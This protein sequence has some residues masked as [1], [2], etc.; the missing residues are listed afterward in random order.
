MFSDLINYLTIILLISYLIYFNKLNVQIGFVLAGLSILPIFLI[1]TIIPINLVSDVIQYTLYT[2]H[3]RAE[4]GL[5]MPVS[6]E[7]LNTLS[8][9][10]GQ[11]VDRIGL[12]YALMPIPFIDNFK[13]IG[14]NNKFLFI[15]LIS[16]IY[17]QKD[18]R[19]YFIIFFLLLY[20]SIIFYSSTGL[21]DTLVLITMVPLA[22][23]IVEKKILGTILLL[24]ILY[25]FRSVNVYLLVPII[26]AY[27]IIFSKIEIPIKVVFFVLASII[28]LIFL[29]IKADSILDTLNSYRLVRAAE[30]ALAGNPIIA[31]EVTINLAE[32]IYQVI[33]SIIIDSIRFFTLPTIF[34]AN[35]NF[36]IIQSVENIFVMA[37]V[38]YLFYKLYLIDKMKCLFWILSLI[39]I[40]GVYGYVQT[41][42]GTLVRYKFVFIAMFTTLL[43]YEIKFKKLK[44][45]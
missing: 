36:E 13:S 20:P 10:E 23:F 34:D 3:H 40:A 39:F 41:N 44:N 45:E 24:S 17:S 6:P 43:V 18:R 15:L 5:G 29:Y 11:T 32:N 16:Y 7:D 27:F 31:A 14:F 21:K 33:L 4:L 2:Q 30:D 42:V 1:G 37:I 38:S 35:S 8:R 19:D 26:S 22:F 28:G 12:L 9:H 25:I